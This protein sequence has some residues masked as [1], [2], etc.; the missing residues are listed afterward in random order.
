M[1]FSLPYPY[2]HDG[3]WAEVAQQEFGSHDGVMKTM[4]D[5]AVDIEDKIG[6]LMS[7]MG[8]YHLRVAQ[9]G[10]DVNY[11]DLMNV[12]EEDHGE[13]DDRGCLSLDSCGHVDRRARKSLHYFE[14]TH[15]EVVNESVVAANEEDR[16]DKD[17]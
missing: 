6:P 16:N 11:D 1:V 8:F 3:A 2:Q 12:M 13:D 5:V 4:R 15:E 14:G 7:G 9:I 10:D 17:P